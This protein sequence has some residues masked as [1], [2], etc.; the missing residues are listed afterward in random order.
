M[1]KS[2]KNSSAEELED[3][4]GGSYL[5][6]LETVKAGVLPDNLWVVS[7]NLIPK[8]CVSKKM[9]TIVAAV[10][11]QVGSDQIVAVSQWAAIAI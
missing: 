1:Q 9:V 8:M 7:G 11:H 2:S 5:G 10:S 3:P 6:A 4:N